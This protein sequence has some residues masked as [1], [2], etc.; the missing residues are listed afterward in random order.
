MKNIVSKTALKTVIALIVVIIAAFG[1]ACFGFPQH[2]ATFFEGAGNYSAASS[3]ASLAYTYSGD[4]NDLARCVDYSILSGDDEKIVKYVTMMA[5]NKRFEEYCE[6]RDEITRNK[7]ENSNV[8][9]KTDYSYKQYVIGNLACSQ[10]AMGDSDLA[11]ET[12]V[13]AME[14]G[15]FPANNVFAMLARRAALNKDTEMKEKL[16]KIISER[17]DV[18]LDEENYRDAVLKI[19]K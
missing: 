9:I 16:Y 11:I 12:A 7:L 1:V 19:L 2:M 6:E 8:E 17:T 14:N 15:G 18:G 10:Y 4:Y 3:F 13:T 5:G